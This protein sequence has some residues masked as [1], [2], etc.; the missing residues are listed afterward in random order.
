MCFQLLFEGTSLQGTCMWANGTFTPTSVFLVV[1]FALPCNK[2]EKRSHLRV[3]QLVLGVRSHVWFRRSTHTD[4]LV[5]YPSS[6]RLAKPSVCGPGTVATSLNGSTPTQRDSRAWS[7]EAQLR[8]LF[9][10]KRFVDRTSDCPRTFTIITHREC[11]LC[12]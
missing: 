10:T 7:I 1:W 6:C 2:A 8:L 3:I 11:S 5:V 4:S 9:N 12:D